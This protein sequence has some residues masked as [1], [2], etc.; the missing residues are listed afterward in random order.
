MG[1]LILSRR[2]NERIKIG[3]DVDLLITDIYKNADGELVV[4]IGLTGPKEVK[5]LRQENY[6]QD[7]KK[8]GTNTRYKSR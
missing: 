1:W 7:L 2:L 6:L 5:F 3:K 4:D 8:N